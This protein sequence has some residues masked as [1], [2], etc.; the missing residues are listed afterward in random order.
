MKGNAIR[1]GQARVRD[2]LTKPQARLARRVKVHEAEMA[3]RGEDVPGR[4]RPGSLK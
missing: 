2:G 3:A 4:P 1:Q